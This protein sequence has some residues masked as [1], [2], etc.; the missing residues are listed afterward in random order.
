MSD[1]RLPSSFRDPS[2]FLFKRDDRVL[3][4]INFSYRDDYDLLMSSGLYTSLTSKGWML[5]HVELDE[6]RPDGCYRIIE[7][8]QLRYV[9]YPYE[10]SFSQLKD[11]ALLTMDVQLEAL[12]NGMQLKDAS[13]YNVQFH[14]GRAVFIDTL[15]FEKYQEGAPWAAY[16]QFCQ[17]FLAPLALIAHRDHRMNRLLSSFI[18]GVPLDLC[19]KLLPRRTWLKYSILAHIHLHARAQQRYEDAGREGQGVQARISNTQLLGLLTSLRNAVSKMH[20]KYALTEWGAYYQDTNYSDSAMLHKEK[21]VSEYL[22]RCRH[23]ESPVAADFG[24]NTGRFSR[25]AAASGYHVLAHDIDEVAVDK[26]YRESVEASEASILPLVQ[27]LTNPSAGI[28]WANRERMSFTERNSLDVGMA[29]ALIHHIAI[30]NNVPLESAAEFFSSLCSH[31]IIEF[32][33]KSDTQ[34]KRLLASR[35]DIFPD[36]D[37]DGFER[38]FRNYFTILESEKLEG[39]ER[40]LYLMARNREPVV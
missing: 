38:A 7:P 37:E 26:N 13:A 14:N 23:T 32:V 15:S 25:L 16:R 12:Q 5:S 17:H 33:P 39:S 29:L 4:Q 2:G 24:A 9:S 22:A 36:Y 31:L 28:G 8:E 20:W 34:V 10:W 21:L 35:A 18:D 3:R 6:E 19:S 1:A 40:T 27:D 30:S 11:A